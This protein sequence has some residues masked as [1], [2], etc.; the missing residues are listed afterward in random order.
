VQIH[1]FKDRDGKWVQT[2]GI[3]S[4]GKPKVGFT[5]AGQHYNN[6]RNRCSEGGTEQKNHPSYIGTK[7][8]KDFMDFQ[9]FADWCQ[10]QVGYD[11]QGWHLDKDILVP[12]NAEYD[13]DTCV[14]VPHKVNQLFRTHNKI[15]G[16]SN[17]I[18]PG[19]CNTFSVR[20]KVGTTRKE[21]HGFHTLEEAQ[22]QFCVF[23]SMQIQI[24]LA[25]FEFALD[26]RVSKK[27]RDFCLKYSC[28]S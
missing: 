13:S 9:I 1:D 17:G 28:T 19:K 12:G 6:M 23:K 21:K 8:S 3:P 22:H 14:F 15:S 26:P 11:M 27:L 24:A 7:I 18:Y 20:A 2:F 10:S 16:L 25:E 5:K 4:N